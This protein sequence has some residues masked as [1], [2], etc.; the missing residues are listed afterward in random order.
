MNYLIFTILSLAVICFFAVFVFSES[1]RLQTLN[2]FYQLIPKIKNQA[3]S[4][5][6]IGGN[7]T[8][9]GGDQSIQTATSAAPN[10]NSSTLNSSTQKWI[11]P[12]FKGPTGPPHIIGPSGPPPD[13]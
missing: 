3:A 2:S 1:M 5:T 8:P 4:T 13:Y 12:G 11:P 10:S 9:K 7:A 6:P